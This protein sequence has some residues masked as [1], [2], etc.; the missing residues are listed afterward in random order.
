MMVP[1][2][3]CS[4]LILQNTLILKVLLLAIDNHAREWLS[5]NGEVFQ[6]TQTTSCLKETVMSK[7]RKNVA[8]TRCTSEKSYF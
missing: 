5:R 8:K 4:D 2:N 7:H 3:H 6:C 1:L